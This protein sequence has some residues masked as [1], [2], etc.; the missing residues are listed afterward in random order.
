MIEEII[1]YLVLFAV[2]AVIAWIY[3]SHLFRIKN[4]ALSLFISLGAGYCILSLISR[5]ENTTANSIAFLA[6]NCIILILNYQCSVK[7]SLL[8][9][10]FLTFIMLMSEVMIA[11]LITQYGYEFAAYTYNFTIKVTLI[12]FSKF[13]YFVITIISARAFSPHKHKNSD[14]RL[15]VVFLAL[16]TIS[17]AFSM[18]IIHIGISSEVTKGSSVIMFLAISVLLFVNLLFMVL[19][20]QQQKLAEDHI[21]LQLSIQQD[22]ADKLYYETL[23]K[24]YDDQKILVHDIRNHLQIINSFAQN[25]TPEKISEYIASLDTA[26]S[27]ATRSI[28]CDNPILNALLLHFRIQCVQEG[29]NFLCDIRSETLKF[30]DSTG[31][32]ALFGNLLSN[33]LEAAAESEAKQIEVSVARVF[34]Q[35][36][37]LISVVNSCDLQ[38][39]ADNNGSYISR[40]KDFT[41]HGIGLKSIERVVKKYNGTQTMYYCRE[42]KTFHHIIQYDIESAMK[43]NIFTDR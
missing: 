28:M 42:E 40:K 22:Q 6:V 41:S 39:E 13:L 17:A 32:T 21:S 30:M 43:K 25:E 5:F 1:C 15:M 37:I 14:P 34:E 27:P 31:I 4:T 29:V 8:H 33:A 3:F 7:S 16:P 11:L 20:N 24:Q 23:Q 10:A 26:L 9:S 19:Y 36:I 2:E 38:P 35:N 18:G 12:I